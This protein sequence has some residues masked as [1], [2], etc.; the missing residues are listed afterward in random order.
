[1]VFL[2]V[3]AVVLLDIDNR[4]VLEGEFHI[5]QSHHGEYVLICEL[6]DELLL[7]RD[8]LRSTAFSGHDCQRRKPCNSD[9][10]RLIIN[11]Q[12]A[13]VDIKHYDIIPL[14]VIVRRDVKD[15]THTP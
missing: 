6:A 9:G 3:L 11:P 7:D 4:S 10:T 15:Q 8:I 12:P 14:Q 5:L 1:M 13:S 2:D